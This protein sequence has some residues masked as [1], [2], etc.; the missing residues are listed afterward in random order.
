M[1][2]SFLA[3]AD[4]KDGSVKLEMQ[5]E[6]GFDPKS[7]AH[8]QLKLILSIMDRVAQYTADQPANEAGLIDNAIDA[9]A[10]AVQLEK[11]DE[12]RILAK[13]AMNNEL[14]RL[15]IADASGK[16]VG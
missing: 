11:L 8:Q 9:Q 16:L 7:H 1:G 12:M 6:G 4:Q 5:Y 10:R 2:I 3:L 13:A 15:V 14:P